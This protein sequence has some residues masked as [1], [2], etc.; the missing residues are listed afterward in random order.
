[1]GLEH[2]VKKDLL[3]V[4]DFDRVETLKIGN[5]NRY[6]TTSMC[7]NFMHKGQG[8]TTTARK[9][10]RY[11]ETFPDLVFDET[12]SYI[13]LG[14]GLGGFVPYLV[15][16]LQVKQKPVVVDVVDYFRMREIF[17]YVMMQKVDDVFKSQ[18]AEFVRLCDIYLSDKIE[19]HNVSIADIDLLGR[20][21]DCCVDLCGCS[22]YNE[23]FKSTKGVEKLVYSAKNSY[24]HVLS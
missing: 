20:K 4:N 1:M 11:K 6:K 19:L 23:K 8:I 12:H 21:F 9:I 14:A 16:K 15:N 7:F 10:D 3:V 2:F 22:M 13:E 5:P 24:V 18:A 17:L